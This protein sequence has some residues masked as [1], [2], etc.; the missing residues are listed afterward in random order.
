MVIINYHILNGDSLAGTFPKAKLLG[1]IIVARECLIEGDL[2]GDSLDEFWRTWSSYIGMTYQE[3][4][5]YY[6]EVAREFEKLIK[7]PANSEFNLW[8]VTICF[9]VLICGL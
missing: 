5:R 4:N 8:L 6:T 9:A 1:E 7:A 2:H 3:Q